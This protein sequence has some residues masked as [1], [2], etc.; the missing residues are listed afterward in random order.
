MKI[1]QFKRKITISN[2]AYATG[3]WTLT[4]SGN[5]LL[6]VGDTFK[7]VN[8]ATNDTITA[9]AIAG[10]TGST[11]KFTYA[12]AN[13]EFSGDFFVYSFPTGF[14]GVSEVETLGT[15]ISTV[16]ATTT[17][18]SGNGTHSVAFQYSNDKVGW[19]TVA[20]SAPASAASPIT[21]GFVLQ[22]PWLYVRL[23]VTSV[24]GT[25]GKMIATLSG[26]RV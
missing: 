16:Q 1:A 9:T 7:I 10:T 3:D 12:V 15:T 17:T 23:N 25:G 13:A 2:A 6:A 24:T 21:D 20:N 11:L 14:S 26:E 4:T 22:A 18:S 19:I 8:K 5:H